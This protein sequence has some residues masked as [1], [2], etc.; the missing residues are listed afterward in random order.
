MLETRS[1]THTVE[2][3]AVEPDPRA[4]RSDGLCRWNAPLSLQESPTAAEWR[5]RDVERA[6]GVAMKIAAPLEQS[7]QVCIDI[8]ADFNTVAF[9]AEGGA[10][11]QRG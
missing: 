7:K 6:A 9:V 10:T 1:A 3:H 11:I 5:R 8:N 2:C 4:G